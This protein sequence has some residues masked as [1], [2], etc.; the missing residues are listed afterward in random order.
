M[1]NIIGFCGSPRKNGNTAYL[2]KTILKNAFG[3]G[4]ETEFVPLHGA[5]I[6]FCSACDACRRTDKGCIQ[7]DDMVDLEEKM[8][9]AD[10]W[11]LGTPVYWWGPTAQMKVF[12][13]RWYG[14]SQ[15]TFKNKKVILVVPMQ[16]TEEKTADNVIGMFR[17]SFEYIG[18][19][20]LDVIIAEGVW[21][22]GE[23]EA[24]NDIL[25]RAEEAAKKI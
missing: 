13:D 15:D 16:D 24:R 1:A 17:D 9:K 12:M 19:E 8:K 20:M 22:A 7:K 6:G 4:H 23:V 5:K 18:I 25:R 21:E 11:I 2:V 10:V 14:F 3:A